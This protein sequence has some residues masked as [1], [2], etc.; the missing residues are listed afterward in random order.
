[1]K[2]ANGADAPWPVVPVSPS[3]PSP[4][5]FR[6]ALHR[7]RG[8]ISFEFI[9]E[10]A[11]GNTPGVLVN[12]ARRDQVRYGDPFRFAVLCIEH[13]LIRAVVQLQVVSQNDV[14]CAVSRVTE[15]VSRIKMLKHSKEACITMAGAAARFRS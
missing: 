12:I 1:M 5:L 8:R 4:I 3:T 14:M 6:L 7:W 11:C 2:R 10:I 9:L 13:D 15:P